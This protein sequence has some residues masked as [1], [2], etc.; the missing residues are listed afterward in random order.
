[1]TDDDCFYCDEPIGDDSRVKGKFTNAHRRCVHAKLDKLNPKWRDHV[2][3][4]RAELQ[5]S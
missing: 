1:M 3:V 5:S 4:R 2:D